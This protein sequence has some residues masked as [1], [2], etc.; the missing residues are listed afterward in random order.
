MH[1]S[2]QIYC[3][4]INLPFHLALLCGVRMFD[5]G[6][7]RFRRTQMIL[8]NTATFKCETRFSVGGLRRMLSS[9]T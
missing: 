3:V 7:V 5:C 4:T 2:G 1:T 9:W 6:I 8:Y